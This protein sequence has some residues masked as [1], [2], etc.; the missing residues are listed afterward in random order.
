MKVKTFLLAIGGIVMLFACSVY[1]EIQPGSFSVSPLVGGYFFDRTQDFKN[2]L[3]YGGGLGYDFTEHFGVEGLYNV[4][5]T[6]TKSTDADVNGYLARIEGLIYFGSNKNLVPYIA[7]GAGSINIKH[8]I[9]KLDKRFGEFGF[10]LKYFLS[11]KIAFRADIRDIMVPSKFNPLITA[12]LTFHFGGAR[13]VEA[14]EEKPVPQIKDSD[15]D[16][17]TDDMDKCPNTPAG[18]KVDSVGCPLDSDKDGVTDDMDKCPNTPSGVKVDSMGCPLD[19]DKD[20][21]PDYLDKC[22]NTPAGVKVDGVGCPLD[23]DKDEVPD[24]LDKCPDTPMGVKVDSVGCPLDSDG[25]GVIDTNDQC[26]DTPKG[27]AVDKRGCWVIKDLQFDTAKATIKPQYIKQLDD[28]VTILK[29]NPSLK[30][31]IQGHTDNVGKEKYNEKLS[32]K[33]AQA[34]MEFLEKKGIDKNRLNAK[35]YGFS[36]PAASND[37]PEGRAENRRVELTR[38]Q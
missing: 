32:I 1:A 13:K 21:V 30:V 17:V 34:V 9:N 38:I 29:E 22:P 33:R 7:V 4:L 37:T 3:T 10:G 12:G 14:A 20:G 2:T 18:V 36:K 31:E 25:D 19:S 5:D 11:D 23:S 35:G 8:P 6:K 24:Y 28:V 27:A 16:G 26:P 15:G